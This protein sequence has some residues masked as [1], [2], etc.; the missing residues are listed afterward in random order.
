MIVLTALNRSVIKKC[1]ATTILFL[2]SL[3]PKHSVA[4]T[5]AVLYGPKTLQVPMNGK[6]ALTANFQAAN[7]S[8]G[9]I[10][11]KN[12]DGRDLSI[13]DC[14]GH[15]REKLACELG[16]LEFRLLALFQRPRNVE[17]QLNGAVVG[18]SEMLP[19]NLGSLSIPVKLSAQNT[20]QV[21]LKGFLGSNLTV[22]VL[23]QPAHVNLPPVA[24]FTFSPDHEIAP[25]TLTFSA[26]SSHDPDGVI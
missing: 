22:T 21:S 14:P 15:G 9:F 2:L 12:G 18:T 19:Q 24:S 7:S 10:V 20:L 1:F 25:A 17:I 11:I 23:G 3:S 13:K 5:G 6:A 4:A 8:D 16:N 26:L